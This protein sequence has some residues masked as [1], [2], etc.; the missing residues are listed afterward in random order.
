MGAKGQAWYN[1]GQAWYNIETEDISGLDAVDRARKAA[2]AASD[3]QASDIVLLDIRG[4]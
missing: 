3:K 4:L 2:E 1:K